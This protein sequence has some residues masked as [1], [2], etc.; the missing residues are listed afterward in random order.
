[1]RKLVGLEQWKVRWAFIPKT[2]V[3]FSYP[4]LEKIISGSSSIGRTSAFQAE[5]CEFKSRLPLY[6]KVAQLEE[7]FLAREKVGSPN[8]PFRSNGSMGEWLSIGLQNRPHQFES[9]YCLK[10]ICAFSSDGQS[11][12]LIIGRSLVQ[13]HQGA[14]NK[15]KMK[16][17]N[18]DPL[19][20]HILR[21][22]REYYSAPFDPKTIQKG[23]H[24]KN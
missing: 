17:D 2:G 13:L 18:N 7:H 16:K 20:K 21:Y 3:R 12:R 22:N 19:C 10:N 6:A 5:C 4:I 15:S 9:D 11:I 1:M 24:R 23:N 14:L 8:L